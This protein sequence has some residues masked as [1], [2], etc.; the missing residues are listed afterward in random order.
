M[1]IAVLGTGMVGRALAA[2][3]R[4]GGHDVVVGTR[5][6][7]QTL[8]RTEADAKGTA[9]FSQ[10]LKA[11]PDIRLL[12]FADA[13]GR[14][15][16]ILNATAGAICMQAIE[17]VGVDNLAGKVLV[18]LAVPLDYSQ[19][20]PPK[21]SF[22]ISDSLGEQIQ[23]AFPGARVVKTL[24]TMHFTVMVD[25]ARIP[26]THNVFVAGEDGAAKKTVR[27]LLQEF[28]WPDEAII[29]LGGI[30]GARAT[31]MYVPMLFQLFSALKTYDLNIS[32]LR[33]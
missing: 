7:E 16:V 12:T 15:K 31:E 32:V 3:L 19:G 28:G 5:D 27:I 25:P 6:V 4:E 8:S 23:R 11:H 26:G 21:L 2:R 9:P 33:P 20:R 13:G 18:D 17:A 22:G 24:N 10:W 30:Q 29:D 1:K 14:S